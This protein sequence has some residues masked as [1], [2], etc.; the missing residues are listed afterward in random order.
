M[1][2]KNLKSIKIFYFIFIKNIKVFLTQFQ[3]FFKYQY[4]FRVFPTQLQLFLK[5]LQKFIFT[6]LSACK[7]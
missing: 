4:Y 7:F 3:L 1:E 2:F 6:A 5:I